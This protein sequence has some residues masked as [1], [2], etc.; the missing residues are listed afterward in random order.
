MVG[1]LKAVSGG[2][3]LGLAAA[4]VA[5]AGAVLPVGGEAATSA[6]S[7]ALS[8]QVLLGPLPVMTVTADLALPTA[9]AEGAYRAD[10]VGRAGGYVGEVYDW[11][12]TAR[13]EGVARGHR[14]SPKRFAG[15]NLSAL[16]PRPVA[17]A[18]A[19]DGTPQ[20]RFD[21]PRPDDAQAR[22]TPAQ[23]KGTLDPA[24]AM[25]ALL[26]TVSAT[27]SC[28]AALPVYDG[29]RRFDLITRETGEELIEALPR[30]AYGGP[31]RR[32]ELQVNQLDDS[33]ERLPSQGTA[34]VAEIAGATVPVRL[35][36]TTA[37]GIVT[38]DLVQATAA[39]SS[40]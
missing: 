37:L 38:V 36:L 20:P 29:R 32:C 6:K 5:L 14:L 27:G 16:D 18:Y 2:V 26:R 30:S 19:Q 40:L 10:I 31:A 34:W 23:A 22:P 13:S 39:P 3:R 11:S 24:S 1:F 17:I 7:L 21:P 9:T 8:Y 15:E 33:R 25:V 12:F 4:A 28:A 35:E